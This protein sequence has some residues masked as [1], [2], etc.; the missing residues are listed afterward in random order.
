[1]TN[2]LLI[3]RL[4]D[5]LLQIR[6]IGQ[7]LSTVSLTASISLGI[8]KRRSDV[9]SNDETC[10]RTMRGIAAELKRWTMLDKRK[11][12]YRKL[13][14]QTFRLEAFTSWVLR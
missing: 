13:G 4:Q 11:T 8:R 5:I 3:L 6:K 7:A 14:M 12:V 10:A 9:I 1:M 2:S